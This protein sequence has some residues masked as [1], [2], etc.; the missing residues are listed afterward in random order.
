VFLISLSAF[1]IRLTLLLLTAAAL[2]AS[3]LH[4]SGIAMPTCKRPHVITKFTFATPRSASCG[5]VSQFSLGEK[6]KT[7]YGMVRW[8]MRRFA[9]KCAR[10]GMAHWRTFAELRAASFD[11]PNSSAGASFARPYSVR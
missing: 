9:R 10:H 6:E 4:C 7:R 2:N 8:V 1:L 11:K 5:R 3:G